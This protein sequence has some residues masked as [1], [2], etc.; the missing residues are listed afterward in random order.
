MNIFYYNRNLPCIMFF[1]MRLHICV[2]CV[3]V[4]A[5]DTLAGSDTKLTVED[6]FSPDFYVHDPEARWMNGKT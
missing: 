6:L 4:L 1:L 5:A 3:C 2:V